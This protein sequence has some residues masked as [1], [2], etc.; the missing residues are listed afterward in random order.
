NGAGERHLEPVEHPR[1]AERD[2]DER[3]KARPRQRVEARR[4]RAFDDS[5]ARRLL[6]A[7]CRVPPLPGRLP[8]ASTA[9]TVSANV[10]WSLASSAPTP[11]SLR[12]ISSP[13]PFLIVTTTV[14][15]HGSASAGCRM[16]PSMRNGVIAGAGAES[17]PA[18]KRR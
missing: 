4:D 7:Q 11:I 17:P 2:D 1:D 5:S 3:M 6:N 13:R 10:H 16:P 14:Y 9:S 18:S 15:S 12:A 8:L